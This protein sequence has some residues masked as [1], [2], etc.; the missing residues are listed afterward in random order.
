MAG[1]VAALRRDATGGLSARELFNAVRWRVRASA[2]E[3]RDWRGVIDGLRPYTPLLWAALPTAERLRFLRHIRPFWEVHRHRMAP[4]VA[5]QME[6]LRREGLLKIA[7]A[8][9]LSAEAHP[10]RVDISIQRRETGKIE[11]LSTAWVIN[12]T[13]PGAHTK[14]HPSRVVASL[15]DAGHLQPDPLHLGVCTGP[16]GE[17]LFARGYGR[18]DLVVIGTLRKPQL[19]ETTAVPELRKQ[20]AVA[21]ETVMEALSVVRSS[22]MR[23]A[24]AL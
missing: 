11:R 16:R 21:A 2:R 22:G 1:F 20:A 4:A 10:D 12:C 5:Q 13:G 14:N 15:L 8:K 24:I 18:T 17:A 23:S 7:A 19:W 3:G 6:A 9:L